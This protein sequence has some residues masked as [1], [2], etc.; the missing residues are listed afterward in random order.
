MRASK[1]SRYD[2]GRRGWYARRTWMDLR[3]ALHLPTASHGRLPESPSPSAAAAESKQD[4]ALRVPTTTATIRCRTWPRT[5]K[6]DAPSRTLIERGALGTDILH[7]TCI[8]YVSK[9][10]PRDVPWATIQDAGPVEWV[11]SMGCRMEEDMGASTPIHW[12]L[13]ASPFPAGMSKFPPTYHLNRRRK[14]KGGIPIGYTA[15][16]PSLGAPY[17]AWPGVVSGT[18]PTCGVG[19]D[20]AKTPPIRRLIHIMAIES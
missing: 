11:H 2:D 19:V 20:S 1:Q 4:D 9:Y 5:D 15:A 6:G 10:L 17:S 14:E 12:C 13:R 16:E 3:A 8:P 7:M 18:N